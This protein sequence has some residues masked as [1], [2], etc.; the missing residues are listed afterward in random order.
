LNIVPLLGN[1]ILSKENFVLLH[2]LLLLSEKEFKETTNNARS[3]ITPGHLPSS[4]FFWLHHP[5][6]SAGWLG[7]EQGLRLPGIAIKDVS[8]RGRKAFVQSIEFSIWVFG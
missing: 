1:L 6:L 8:A 5:R 2:N 4:Y 7:R 3:M